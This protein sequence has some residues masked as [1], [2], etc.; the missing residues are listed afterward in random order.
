M[1]IEQSEFINE[2]YEEVHPD[3]AQWAK[4]LIEEKGMSISE[5]KAAMQR[6]VDYIQK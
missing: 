6:L 2:L 5:V 1:T 4:N 3:I